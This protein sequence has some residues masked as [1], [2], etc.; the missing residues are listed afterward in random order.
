MV[1]RWDNSGYTRA[2][3]R[4]R[5]Y[6]DIVRTCR[7]VNTCWVV[8]A[9]VN[10]REPCWVVVAG[11]DVWE[12]CWVVVAEVD[13]WEP[14]WVLVVVGVDVWKP[15]WVVGVVWE[16]CLVVV[17]GVDV[18]EHCWMV[19][20]TVKVW[21]PYWVVYEHSIFRIGLFRKKKMEKDHIHVE[22]L[23]NISKNRKN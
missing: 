14:C 21:E 6:S 23:I 15:C 18:W 19:V 1:S 22:G 10:V 20:A 5:C 12:P 8:V 13:V 3:A 7:N 17:V 16:P 9:G 2:S 11:V 4:Q